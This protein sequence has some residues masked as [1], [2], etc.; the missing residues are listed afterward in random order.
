VFSNAKF[1]FLGRGGVKAE[2]KVEV[3]MGSGN[4]RSKKNGFLPLTEGVA[5]L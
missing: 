1:I 2:V 4:I 3:E 5:L